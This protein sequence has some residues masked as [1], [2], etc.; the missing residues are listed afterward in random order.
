MFGEL[1]FELDEEI[2]ERGINSFQVLNVNGK[3]LISSIIW[4]IEK[5][6]QPIPKRYITD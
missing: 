5:S 2:G 6:G 1:N 4:D 3:W